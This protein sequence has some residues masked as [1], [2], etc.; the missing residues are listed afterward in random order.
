MDSSKKEK[1]KE[2]KQVSIHLEKTKNIHIGKG[3][4]NPNDSNLKLTKLENKIEDTPLNDGIKE[5]VLINSKNSDI[6]YRGKEVQQDYFFILMN[7]NSDKNSIQMYPIDK[8]ANI[9]LS[10][11]KVEEKIENIE[12]LIKKEKEEKKK[13]IKNF[14]ELF[15]IDNEKEKKK[16]KGKDIP[17]KRKGIKKEFNTNLNLKGLLSLIT[18]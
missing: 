17:K 5:L 8:C 18:S 4:I 3:S 7:Y 9:N 10:A 16:K 12:D 1:E 14:K 11:I 6:I 15:N 13:K 2:T